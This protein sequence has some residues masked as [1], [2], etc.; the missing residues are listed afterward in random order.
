M[1]KPKKNHG[2]LGMTH[3]TYVPLP[4]RTRITISQ[5]I[6]EGYTR[7]GYRNSF[8]MYGFSHLEVQASIEEALLMLY[9]AKGG[10]KK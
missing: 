3:E 2:Y 4:V 10:K 6:N 5:Y 7:I 8:L 1:K 9:L